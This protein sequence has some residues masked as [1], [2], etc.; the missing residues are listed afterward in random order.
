MRVL[1]AFQVRVKRAKS[2][3]VVA[4]IV[5]PNRPVLLPRVGECF[6]DAR[7]VL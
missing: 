4:G 3:R 5:M 2:L 7:K 1:R 6:A